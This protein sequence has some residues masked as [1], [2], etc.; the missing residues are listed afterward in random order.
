VLADHLTSSLCLV[1][2]CVLGGGSFATA[3]GAAIARRKATLDVVMLLR[4]E[5]VCEH[6]NNTNENSRYLPGIKLPPNLRATTNAQE[7]IRGSEY[8]IHAVPVQAS[9]VFLQGIK[10]LLGKDV[11]VVCVSKGIEQRTGF[12]LSELIPSALGRDQPTVFLSGPSFAKEV[13][14][15]AVQCAS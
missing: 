8:A 10:D 14:T 7:A 15:T 2:V 6:I 5:S 9:R 3:M 12:L 13:R 4:R 1:Q 11:P